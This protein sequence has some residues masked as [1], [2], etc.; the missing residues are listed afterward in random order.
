MNTRFFIALVCALAV[1]TVAAN[2]ASQ[3]PYE[4]PR[5]AAD[6]DGSRTPAVHLIPLLD[7][8]WEEIRSDDDPAQPFSTRMTC[9][10]CHDYSTIGMGWH[11]N[12]S[13]GNSRAGRPGEPWF[14]IDKDTGTQVPLSYRPW[15]G[16]WTPEQLGLTPWDFVKTFGR[17]MPGGDVG[18]KVED[19]PDM[20]ARWDISGHLEINCLVCHNASPDQNQSEWVF[21]VGRENFR[22]A[23]T[24]ASGL[25]VVRNMASKLPDWFD[26]VF[27]PNPD[28]LWNM[29][30]KVDYDKAKFDP[31]QRVFFD[32]VRDPPPE[33]C[34]FCHSTTPAD[35]NMAKSW[36]NDGDVHMTTGGFTCIDCHRNGLDHFITRGYEGESSHPQ[37]ASLTCAGCHLGEGCEGSPEAE[38]G[39]LGAPVPTHD[40][41]PESHLEEMTC[42][43]CHAGPL[44]TQDVGR[45]K[46]SRANRLGI[47]GAAQWDTELPYI[48]APVFLKQADGTIAP[49]NIM[50]PAYWGVM[51]EQEV[52]PLPVEAVAPFVTVLRQTKAFE[53]LKAEWQK[54]ETDTAEVELDY[55]TEDAKVKAQEGLEKAGK[56][57]AIAVEETTAESAA[58]LLAANTAFQVAVADFKRFL[59]AQLEA[60]E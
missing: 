31:D 44:P 45:V 27:G 33:R 28:D 29:P 23:A 18:E 4:G 15:P 57:N 38:G 10:D 30:P 14:L 48:L 8:A 24:G 13:A 50:W 6:I 26:P 35:T 2:A 60:E 59:A 56:A 7:E 21:Q 37:T 53:A 16:T 3:T 12:A 17:H 54:A 11:F 34:Y 43:A 5:R 42:T 58:N 39:R 25:G 46:T 1:F 36:Q 47:H 20:N 40:G 41:L 19:P 32:V 55:D 22:W 49:Q 52:T 9:G 51:K